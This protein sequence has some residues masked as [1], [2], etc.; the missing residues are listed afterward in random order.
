MTVT[1]AI[2]RRELGDLSARQLQALEQRLRLSFT[3]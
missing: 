2:V 1:T 3:I